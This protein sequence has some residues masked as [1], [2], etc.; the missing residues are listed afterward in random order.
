MSAN[1]RDISPFYNSTL[2][3]DDH[4]T[5]TNRMET[6]EHFNL[7]LWINC[8]PHAWIFVCSALFL[9]CL[10][11]SLDTALPR[12]MLFCSF[13]RLPTLVY[14]P[15]Y[16]MATIPNLHRFSTTFM[17][18]QTDCHTV[19]TLYRYITNF[20]LFYV[21]SSI[22][23]PASKFYFITLKTTYLKPCC[24]SKPILTATQSTRSYIFN[25]FNVKNL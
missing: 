8:S 6:L 5:E 14:F 24:A 1:M 20:S 16:S 17:F 3:N 19:I 15:H 22:H 7:F 25:D 23:C 11:R 12:P 18:A 21:K 2:S 10:I 4:L 13:L 9:L